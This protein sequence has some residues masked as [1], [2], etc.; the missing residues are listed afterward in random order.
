[1]SFQIKNDGKELERDLLAGAV[2]GTLCFYFR[3]CRFH[4]WSGN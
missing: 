2:A 1:M 4:P 3:A